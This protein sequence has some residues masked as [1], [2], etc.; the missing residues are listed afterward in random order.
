MIRVKNL[1]EIL[2]TSML[3]NLLKYYVGF[4]QKNRITIIMYMREVINLV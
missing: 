2:T 1:F 3:K 4:K